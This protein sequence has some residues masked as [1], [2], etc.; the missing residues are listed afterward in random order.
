MGAPHLLSAAYIRRARCPSRRP[1]ATRRRVPNRLALPPLTSLLRCQVLDDDDDFA[2]FASSAVLSTAAA[3]NATSGM[4]PPAAAVV[5]SASPALAT[6]PTAEEK[7][8]R[9]AAAVAAVQAGCQ[10]AAP[11]ANYGV[12]AGAPLGPYVLGMPQGPCSVPPQTCSYPSNLNT[13]PTGTYPP[14][15]QHQQPP[16]PSHQPPPPGYGYTPP[17]NQQQT[18]CYPPYQQPYYG[19][20]YPSL[21]QQNYPPPR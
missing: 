21:Q 7:A 11:T 17:H 13:P 4:P 20:N 5:S 16:Y 14:F 18:C 2:D 10:S 15:P 19:S 3:P 1:T 12:V 8:A 9:T 6:Q